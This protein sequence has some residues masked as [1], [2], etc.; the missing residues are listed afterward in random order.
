ME[1]VKIINKIM[2]DHFPWLEENKKMEET[3]INKEQ[4]TINVRLNILQER[5]KLIKRDIEFLRREDCKTEADYE[6]ECQRLNRA[7]EQYEKSIKLLKKQL[8]KI[9]EVKGKKR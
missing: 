5:L 2:V 3:E 7:E 1:E 6:L 9:T 4:S 8:E